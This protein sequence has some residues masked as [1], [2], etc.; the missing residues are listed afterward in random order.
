M[1]SPDKKLHKPI[2]ASARKRVWRTPVV[3]KSQMTRTEA[4]VTYNPLETTPPY[5][6]PEGTS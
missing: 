2:G 5:S 6:P 1:P 4:K 3:I